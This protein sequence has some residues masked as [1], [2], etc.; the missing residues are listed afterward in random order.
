MKQYLIIGNGPSAA[1]CIE[2][3]RAVDAKGL[4]LF[5]K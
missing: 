4:R 1:G 3:I 5:D 2:G